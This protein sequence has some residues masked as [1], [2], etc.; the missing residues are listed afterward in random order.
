MVEA[1]TP[2][3]LTQAQEKDHD[4]NDY[5]GCRVVIPPA[6]VPGALVG[7][8]MRMVGK[9]TYVELSLFLTE[10]GTKLGLKHAGIDPKGNKVDPWLL[11]S[12]RF[13]A[14][15]LIEIR[16]ISQKLPGYTLEVRWTDPEGEQH[17]AAIEGFGDPGAWSYDKD[18]P[19][20]FAR[21]VD[22]GGSMKDPELLIYIVCGKATA[23]F[24]LLG[25]YQAGSR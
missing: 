4:R 21:S 20:I 24:T 25:A 22:V 13:G 5:T 19:S 15:H 14:P 16:A 12:D 8:R 3:P 6:G 1:S 2:I 10:G 17:V 18:M 9:A 23:W 11:Q 7:S